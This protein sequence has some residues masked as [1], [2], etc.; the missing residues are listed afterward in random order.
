MLPLPKP[1]DD[2]LLYSVFARAFVYA[3]P[4]AVNSGNAALFGGRHFS[5]LF[6][7]HLDKVAEET[8]A[9]WGL[10]G[11]E[12]IEEYTL[13][14]FYGYYMQPKRYLEC[15]KIVKGQAK[16]NISV[17]VGSQSQ[18]SVEQPKRLRFCRSCATNDLKAYGETYWRRTHQL[19]G[20]LVCLEHKEV[21]R[22]SNASVTHG[23]AEK[24]QD[25][26][27][28]IDIS[29]APECAAL[30]PEQIDIAYKVARRCVD[31]L[32]GCDTEWISAH[33]PSLYC[34]EV[35]ANGCAISGTRTSSQQIISDFEKLF[36]ADLLKKL[37]C[38]FSPR[39]S[40]LLRIF[41]TTGKNHFHPLLHALTQIFLELRFNSPTHSS[42]NVTKRG[43]DVLVTGWKCP[44]PYADHDR[45]FR[46]QNAT[47]R[48]RWGKTVYSVHCSCGFGFSFSGGLELDPLLP[49][50]T[51]VFAWGPFYE[52]EAKRL[53]RMGLSIYKIAAKMKVCHEV[54]TRLVSGEKN[55]YELNKKEL[56]DLRREWKKSKENR[57]YLKLLRVDREW[58]LAQKKSTSRNGKGR[59]KDWAALD[60]D[61]A[62]R[63]IAAVARLKE[64][65]PA[66]QIA[67]R[68]LEEETGIKALKQK[69]SKMPACAAILAKVIESRTYPQDFRKRVIQ[70]MESEG[71]T[72]RAAAARFGVS[73]SAVIDWR[74]LFRGNSH[75]Q[76][77]GMG[78]D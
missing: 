1:Y 50:I 70:T 30:S 21:L 22:N 55:R 59:S 8:K 61:Y 37:G 35:R 17:I 39:S 9:I 58:V 5:V 63:L 29:A 19:P 56:L 41:R 31:F 3:A 68:T 75:R 52:A 4:A 65:V 57:L 26:T 42:S 67:Y 15:L 34:H 62:P 47:R 14:P 32:H 66:R 73:E 49:D 16:G 25:A 44:N 13:L 6:G 33:L 53:K 76:P 7:S 54:A 10:S 78:A 23:K 28:S 43:S 72:P 11:L 77:N 51:R 40:W 12:I 71:M 64:L 36:G 60:K 74:E 48:D 2:E 69:A 27:T 45:S 18:G 20:A 24:P 46:I 38:E